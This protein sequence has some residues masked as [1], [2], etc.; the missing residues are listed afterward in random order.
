[1]LGSPL[2]SL[3]LVPV[4]DLV[5]HEA[6]EPSRARAV[7]SGL[8][9]SGVQTDPVVAAPGPDGRWL[10]LDGAHRTAGLAGLDIPVAV[11]QRMGLLG[12]SDRAG[13]AGADQPLARL[14][15]WAHDIRGIDVDELLAG[16]PAAGADCRP[17][18]LSIATLSAPGREPIRP[19]SGD[20][21]QDRLAAMW[22][23]ARRYADHD[24]VRT[25]PEDP[26]PAGTSVR[27]DWAPIQAADL[28]ELAITG[29]AFPPGVSRF[30]VR[31][32][33]LGIRVPLSD[34]R[35]AAPSG[36]LDPE[37]AD[38]LLRRLRGLPVRHYREPVWVV[39]TSQPEFGI[40]PVADPRV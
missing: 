22:A 14:D 34:L 38:R 10:V 13:V 5:L 20:G 35:L 37:V 9:R 29:Q 24:Y 39:E 23:L 7:A 12:W 27:V 25:H 40:A 26:P 19:V 1:M 30:V 31:G 28:A 32:R 17:G 18:E 4:A 6:V 3:T 16:Q 36:R 33:L 8:D 21:L 2:D 11:V 15:A